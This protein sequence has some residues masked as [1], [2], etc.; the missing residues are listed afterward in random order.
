[1]QSQPE[2][3]AG[4]ECVEICGEAGGGAMAREPGRKDRGGISAE[5]FGFS[6]DRRGAGR[7]IPARPGSVGTRGGKVGRE[8]CDTVCGAGRVGIEKG[9]DPG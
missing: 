7:P 9:L 2:S 5:V 6:R 4:V 1:M 3:G 8:P